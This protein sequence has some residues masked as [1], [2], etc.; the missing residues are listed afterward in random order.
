[1]TYTVTTKLERKGNGIKIEDAITFFRDLD[2]NKIS[3]GVHS[4]AGA[5]FVKRAV[6]TEFGGYW[7][8]EPFGASG[9]VPPRPAI[10]MYLYPEM[11]E[12]VTSTYSKSINNEKR[13]KLRNPNSNSLNVQK[14]VGEKCKTLQ[15]D[16]M[17]NGGY[18]VYGTGNK[19]DPEHNG[20]KTIAWKGFDDPWIGTGETVSKVD[21]KVTKR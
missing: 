21:Y 8:E 18:Y 12:E 5:E 19:F 20:Q 2:K 3:S 4:D 9:T 6:H 7:N 17:T 10:R 14:E 1:M 15:K 11:K 13:G 16:K